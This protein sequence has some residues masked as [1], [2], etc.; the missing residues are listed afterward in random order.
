MKKRQRTAQEKLDRLK[1][2]VY[3][4]AILFLAVIELYYFFRG[5][6]LLDSV[7][8]LMMGAGGAGVLIE[9]AFWNAKRL[10]NQ[11]DDELQNS[12]RHFRQMVSLHTATTALVMT[13][14]L[15]ELLERILEATLNAIQPA[16]TGSIYLVDPETEQL[17][18]EALRGEDL[19]D[20]ESSQDLEA[21]TFAYEQGYADQA[22]QSKEA[23]L[24]S[25]VHH[26]L[27]DQDVQDGESKFA[28]RSLILAPLLLEDHGVGVLALNSFSVEAFSDMDL[29]SLRTFATTAAAAILNARLYEEAHYLAITD[30]LTELNNRRHFFDLARAELDR[31]QRYQRSL[32]LLMLDLDHFKHV[33][34]R[35]GHTVGDQVL[36]AVAARCKETIRKQDIIGRYGGEEFAL[37]LPET[38]TQ[39]A[40]NTANRIRVSIAETPFAASNGDEINL[41]VSIGIA[42]LDKHT[43]DLTTFISAADSALY[44]AKESGKDCIV[45]A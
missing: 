14:D 22:I 34:D 23:I 41:T 4:L 43:R 45:V 13:H 37:I 6:P 28:V 44:K 10:Q 24:I 30:V 9:F 36:Q 20:M 42:T 2:K 25:D 16:N 7:L 17:K 31:S 29:T 32:S 11:L 39:A 19:F 35:Y 27:E 18:L 1:W 40:H 26:E 8:D 3:G 5:V 15:R 38:D 21:F 12:R 33:N